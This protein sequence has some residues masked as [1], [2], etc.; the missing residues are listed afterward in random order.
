MIQKCPSCSHK[1]HSQ[2]ELHGAG[3]RVFNEHPTK[4]HNIQRC[5][6]CGHEI[7]KPRG[8]S[9]SEPTKA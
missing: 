1:R 6:V 9:S 8:S 7:S 5:T 2:D 4:T 3:N